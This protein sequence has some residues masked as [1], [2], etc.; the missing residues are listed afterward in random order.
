MVK[1][2]QDIGKRLVFSFRKFL[3]SALRRESGIK[4][5]AQILRFAKPIQVKCCLFLFQS[6]QFKLEIWTWINAAQIFS[7]AKKR[8]RLNAL[9][10]YFYL[11]N[12]NLNPTKDLEFGTVPTVEMFCC[13]NYFLP[14][15]LCICLL[16]LVGWS[17]KEHISMQKKTSTLRL[18]WN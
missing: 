17:A 10:I 5:A 3:F 4:D 18:E 14:A 1:Y 11:L 15:K 13:F 12:L 7:F 2:W 8:L 9:F 6:F 16:K